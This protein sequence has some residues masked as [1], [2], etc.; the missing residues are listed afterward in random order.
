MVNQRYRILC[1]GVS[2]IAFWYTSAYA[3]DLKTLM[4]IGASQADIAKTLQQETKVY[5]GVKSAIDSG[6]IKK[7]MAADK[8]R[9]K[10]GEPVISV[11]DKKREAD[12]WLYMPSESTH[13]KG[14]KIYLYFDKENKLTEWEKIE[15]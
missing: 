9:K 1:A 10:Y 13:F 2:I 15:Q 11:Y 4:E 6:A 8:L 12:K 7:G 5:N 14:E 3:A